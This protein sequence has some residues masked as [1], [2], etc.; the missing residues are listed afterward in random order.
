MFCGG[1][2]TEHHCWGYPYSQSGVYWSLLNNNERIGVRWYSFSDVNGILQLGV[3][4]LDKWVLLH[5][6]LG[7][8]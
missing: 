7:K 3:Q 1:S 2:H 5:I 8:D 4:D 6:H